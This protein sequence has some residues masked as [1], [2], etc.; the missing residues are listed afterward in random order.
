[1]IYDTEGEKV[2]RM[3]NINTFGI[4]FLTPYICNG[5]DGCLTLINSSGSKRIIRESFGEIENAIAVKDVKVQKFSD[6]LSE[7][8]TL[9]YCQKTSRIYLL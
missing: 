1:M 7:E 4:I 9:Y 8:Y 6:A 3:G 5:S 2:T